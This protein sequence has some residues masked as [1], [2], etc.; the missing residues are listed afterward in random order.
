[1]DRLGLGGVQ[2][3]P[4]SVGGTDIR[5]YGGG[6]VEPWDVSRSLTTSLKTWP[7][8]DITSSTP[9]LPQWNNICHILVTTNAKLD[10]RSTIW[11]DAAEGLG[12]LAPSVLLAFTTDLLEK[13]QAGCEGRQP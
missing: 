13:M 4:A 2:V 11:T 1:M 3:C 12:C 6:A 10:F 9:I 5:I 7:L 8:I